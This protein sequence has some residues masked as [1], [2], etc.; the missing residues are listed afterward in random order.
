MDGQSVETLQGGTLTIEVEGE[1]V[2]LVDATGN[3]IN[4]TDIDASNGV[5]HAVDAVLNPTPIRIPEYPVRR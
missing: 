5:I 4:V 2:V 3:R 1:Q